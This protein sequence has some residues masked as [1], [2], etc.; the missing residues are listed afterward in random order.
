MSDEL[1][2][3]DCE[4][5]SDEWFQARL[6]IPTASEFATVVAQGRTK[7]APSVTRRKYLLTLAGEVITGEIADKWEGNRHTERGKV[8]EAEARD[9]YAFLRSV[10]PMPV[11]F[12]RRGRAG[13]SP[14]SLI[15]DDGLLEIKTKLPHLQLDVL[16]RDVLPAEHVAQVQGQ[17]MVSGRAW[18]DFVSYW[19]GLPLFVKRVERDDAYIR[20]LRTELARFLAELDSYVVRFRPQEAA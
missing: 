13:A 1:V 9:A 5:G 2:I 10:T 12:M 15:G 19:P 18:C 3:Y 8:M 7:G 17:L 6:G 4:Q 16:E 11:G 14:D 20:V